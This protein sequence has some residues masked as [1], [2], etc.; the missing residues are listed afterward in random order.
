MRRSSLTLAIAIAFAPGFAHADDLLQAYNL[1]RNSDP[2]FAGAEA[3]NRAV[4]ENAVQARAAM[5]PQISGSVTGSASSSKSDSGT[6]TTIDPNTGLPITVNGNSTTNSRSLSSGISLSQ[7]VFDPA[8]NARL[9]SARA[10]GKASDM[11]LNAAGDTLITRTSQAYFNVLIAL[12]TLNAADSRETALKKQFDFASKR[13]EVGLAPITDVHEARAQYDDARANT[14][15]ARNAVDDAYQ[16]LR[17]ITGAPVSNLMALPDNFKPSLPAEGPVEA[18][19]QRAFEN[20]PTLA[21]QKF[22]VEAAEEGIASARAGYLPRLYA[23]AGYDVRKS[24]TT[25]K[26]AGTSRSTDGMNDG[27]SVGL[28]L[29]V[30]IFNGG[31]TASQVRQA[32]AQR[33]G[34]QDQMEATRR[35]LE[36]NTRAAYQGLVAGI[37]SVEARRSA[38]ESAQAAY[39]ASLVG[40]EVGTRTVIDVLINQQN[41]FNAKQAYSQAKYNFLQSRLVLEQSAGTLNVDDLADVNR[42]LTVPA[43]KVGKMAPAAT[44]S[45]AKKK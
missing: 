22:N 42:M 36:R 25:R 35:G 3:N 1:A 18:W 40:L 26:S 41:L 31:A 37:S 44:T 7:M 20:N 32:I 28:Q 9:R 38:L 17:E 39:D 29:S 14:I 2:T 21:A 34:A 45:K 30:P 8:A 10:S 11:T 23:S 16:A 12:E 24:W 19:V 6:T 13:L 27:P 5:L 43:E 33:D 15:L 4:K